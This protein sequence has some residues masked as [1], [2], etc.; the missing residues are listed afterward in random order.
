MW[1]NRKEGDSP[2]VAKYPIASFEHF[3]RGEMFS[4]KGVGVTTL[5]VI[6]VSICLFQ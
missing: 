6:N 1:F 5:E 4:F 2:Y 3:L